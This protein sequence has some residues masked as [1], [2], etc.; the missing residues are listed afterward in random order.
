VPP[1]REYHTPPRNFASPTS[2]AGAP[3]TQQGTKHHGITTTNATAANAAA[4]V[5]QEAELE[6]NDSTI[7]WGFAISIPV[8]M[9]AGTRY[10]DAYEAF[11][12]L[13]ER[14]NAALDHICAEL[15][16]DDAGIVA[17]CEFELVD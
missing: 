7:G 3:A 17:D 12:R 8:Q 11:V 5:A 13:A 1:N 2:A 6:L 16:K 9:P 4:D 10:G 15:P 14:V